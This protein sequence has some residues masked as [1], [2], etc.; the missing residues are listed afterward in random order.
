MHREKL[1]AVAIVGAGTMG[2]QIALQ[3]AA[4]GTPIHLHDRDEHM[5]AAAMERIRSEGRAL[6]DSGELP[7]GAR[8]ATLR[9][10]RSSTLEEA[11]AGCW[12]VIEAIPELME[13]KR[14]LFG[15]VSR[16]VAPGVILATNSSSFKSAHLFDVTTHPERLMNSHFYNVPWRR[17]GVELMSCGLTDERSIER[18]AAFV[19]QCGLVPVIAQAQ[20]TGFVFNRVWHA[21]KRESLKVVAEGVA[22]AE[23]VDRL[24]CLSM[25]AAIGPFAMMD[26]VGLD[27]VLDIERHYAEQSGNPEDEPPAFL[28][29]MV[30]RGLLGRKSGRGFY[31]Y[32]NPTWQRPGWPRDA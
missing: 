32:P 31:D 28:L 30:E 10:R 25:Q 17:S 6:A 20:S 4:Y 27:V 22:T 5:L 24:W 11:V 16:L 21:V 9:V 7:S 26:R 29:Q 19:R 18:V 14:E 23:E 13:V 2:W 1:D 8:D 12:Y 3:L 15:Q